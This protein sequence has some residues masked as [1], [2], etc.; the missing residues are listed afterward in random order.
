MKEN[1]RKRTESFSGIKLV[2]P[3]LVKRKEG[4]V[5]QRRKHKLAPNAPIVARWTRVSPELHE[6]RPGAYFQTS[7]E[8]SPIKRGSW[9]NG[10]AARSRSSRKTKDRQCILRSL[11]RKR[12]R[13][14]IGTIAERHQWRRFRAFLAYLPLSIGRKIQM[15]KFRSIPRL[16][17]WWGSTLASMLLL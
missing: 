2:Q 16:Q 9:K 8:V 15:R 10:L 5:A 1:S 11:V 14:A 4:A 13:G 7:P 17:F 12:R 3:W 6:K